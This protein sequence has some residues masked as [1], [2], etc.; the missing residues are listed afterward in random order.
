[1][2]SP[3]RRER[4]DLPI[5]KSAI[6]PSRCTRPSAPWLLVSAAAR[7]LTYESQRLCKSRPSIANSRQLASG[8]EGELR[9]RGIDGARYWVSL[10]QRVV[11]T[12]LQKSGLWARARVAS[13]GLVGL[14]R[15]AERTLKQPGDCGLG[16]G[17][18]TEDQ[19]ESPS[20]MLR[21][22]TDEVVVASIETADST[23]PNLAQQR[24][25]SRATMLR[26]NP[27]GQWPPRANGGVV[28][29]GRTTHLKVVA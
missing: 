1:M 29:E 23:K 9:L 2:L 27:N 22:P 16:C 12:R 3:W 14:K 24:D 6:D 7:G 15:S 26:R 8:L 11:E 17:D 13:L 20:V 21:S 5:L 4:S 25:C 18:A 10:D 19:T 28:G